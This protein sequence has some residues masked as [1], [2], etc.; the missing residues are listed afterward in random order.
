MKPIVVFY[1]NKGVGKDTCYELLKPYAFFKGTANSVKMS[2]AEPLRKLCWNLFGAKIKDKE[3][4][5]GSID[6]KEELIE[7]WEIDPKIKTACGFNEDF[8][9]GRRLL[10]W[11]GTDV[12]RAVYDNVWIDMFKQQLNQ[13]MTIP[14]NTIIVVTDCRFMNEY[15]CLKEL[16]ST[17][18]SV[19]F[20]K[21]SRP[22]ESNSFS[23][24]A[25]EGDIDKFEH[26]YEIKNLGSEKDLEEIVQYFYDN[27]LL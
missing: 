2:F 15:N 8:W 16:Q 14:T 17:D 13:I 10:Q 12:G 26:D 27:V 5:W 20:V 4:L 7:G 9:S 23:D 24:H 19:H 11:L 1:G 22:F 25:S 3:R 6:K 21:V 18:Q